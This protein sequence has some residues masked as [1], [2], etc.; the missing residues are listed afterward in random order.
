MNLSVPIREIR[1]S[2]SPSL[3]CASWIAPM[4]RPSI[5]DGAIL[6][7]NENIVAVG[8]K[9]DLRA[10]S[11]NAHVADVGS[12]IL[13]PG[14]I[15]A[16]T[17]LELSDCTQGPAPTGGF[18]QWL[19]GMLQRTRITPE[20]MQAAVTKAINI[21]IN[22]SQKFGVT[23]LG[24]ISRQVHLTRPLL[25][26][27]PLRV[28][29]FGEVQAMAQRRGLLEE[30]LAAAADESVSSS[31]L[32]IGISPHAPYSVEPEGYRRCLQVAKQKNMPLCTHLAETTDEATFL[33]NHSGPLRDL[34]NAWLTWDDQVPKFPGGPIRYAQD[35]GLLDYPTLLAHVNYCDDEELNILAAGKATVV[36]CPRTHKYFGHPLHRWQDMLARNINVSV[37]TDSCASSPDLN[38]VDDLRLL[39]QQYPQVPALEIWQ[40]ATTRAARALGLQ[41][42]CGSLTPGL[43][44]DVVAFPATTNDPLA[45]ILQNNALPSHVWIAG[46]TVSN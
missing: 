5:R 40:L 26:E 3:I 20:E 17:H 6:I 18:A 35:L 29:S 13:I 11:P 42:T 46:R 33:A 24:D 23:T 45:E 16:H 8:P 32:K 1:G 9:K 15:N 36:F 14:L 19:V 38:L 10:K 27:K 31:C 44:A 37:G 4:D 2:N 43:A 28:I 21:G 41:N 7:D 34:W 39:H 12:S 30:R 22:Q 25:L